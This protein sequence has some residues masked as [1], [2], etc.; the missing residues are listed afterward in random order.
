MF[1]Y[2]K[3]PPDSVPKIVV[4]PPGPKAREVIERDHSL[5][6]QSF[7]RWYPLVAKTGLG[8]IIE[9]VDGNLF[10][11]MNAGIAVMGVGHGHPKVVEAIKR[12][13]DK[14]LHYSL[15][16]FYYEEAPEYLE[17]LSKVVPISGGV[18]FFLGNSGAEANEA[19][20]KI[21]K[22]VNEGRRPYVISFIGAFHGRTTG[23]MSLTASKPVQRKGFQP[24]LP[25]V[26]HVPYPYPYRCPF[27]VPPEECGD[28][29]I[30]FLEE[31]IFKRVVDPTEVAA[32]FVEPIQGEG[33]YVVPPD[34]FF[35]KLKKLLS[36]NGILLVDDEV[37]AGMGRTG[38]WFAIEH[39]GVEPDLVTM[40]KAVASGIPLGVVA[41]RKEVM[42]L[43]PGS[44]A[45][46]F[47]GNPV[48]LAAGEAVLQVVRE[49]RLLENAAKVGEAIMRRAKEWMDTYELVGDVR[50]KGLMIGVE[51]VKDR[52]TKEYAKKE[53]AEILMKSYKR[54]VAVIG[55]GFSAI[56]FAPPLVITEE[57]A[58]KA[59]DVIE[60][61]I[62]EVSKECRS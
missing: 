19:A 25:A 40:A 51:L 13:A 33:G 42:D 10:I 9:D 6:M 28:A 50:G 29:A 5:L 8:P 44:H 31:W 11:D 26:I 47:G 53:L 45:S 52:R 3:Y 36:S 4:E 23:A 46:T 38:K 24:L 16:D 55:A 22:G 49:E 12:Q 48:A 41:G 37:Q 21:A 61:A 60:D 15:T 14:L 54:G 39:W 18:K 2:E 59:M 57:L 17:E 62:K 30:G 34:D 27:N 20:M 1:Y 32:V 43:P 35:P 58:M 56:R 7:V